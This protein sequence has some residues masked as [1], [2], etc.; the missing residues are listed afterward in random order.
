MLRLPVFFS[1]LVWFAETPNMKS[2]LTMI[3]EPL[4][5]GLAEQLGVVEIGWERKHL[6]D[7]FFQSEYGWD[8]L[9]ARFHLGLRPRPKHPR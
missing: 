6:G 9:A 1:F 7:F 5:K 3:P 4:E 2:K 8:L